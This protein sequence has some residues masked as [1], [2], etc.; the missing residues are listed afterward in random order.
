MADSYSLIDGQ[1][2]PYHGGRMS[3]STDSWRD[4]TELELEQSERIRELEEVIEKAKELA[5][6]GEGDTLAA[7]DVCAEIYL[8]LDNI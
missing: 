8:L 6:S 1:V 3:T 7:P 4:A 2:V 5:Q